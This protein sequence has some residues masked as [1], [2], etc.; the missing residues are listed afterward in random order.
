MAES[1]LDVF[2]SY[3]HKDKVLRDGLSTALSNLQRQNIIHTW[4]DGD[5]V[6]GSEWQKILMHKLTT[7]HI[8]LL[9]ISADFIASDFCYSK[10][11]GIALER[12]HKG[13]A[14]VIPILLRPCDW[15]GAPFSELQIIPE[16]NKAITKWADRDEAFTEVT[17]G[18]RKSI[19]EFKSRQSRS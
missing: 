15:K 10:E 1:P 19:A 2:I 14:C 7:A 16:N 3:S 4:Y 12:H 13:E 8:I 17:N 11:M 6:P 9:L 5:L 18:I